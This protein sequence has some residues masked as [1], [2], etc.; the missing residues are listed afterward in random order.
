M[1][2]EIKSVHVSQPDAYYYKKLLGEGSFG[3]VRLCIE[4][5]TNESSAL[6]TPKL[7]NELKTSNYNSDSSLPHN[8]KTESD[9]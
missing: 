8:E 5:S 4:S 2:K 7:V 1:P 9:E 6:T 3:R